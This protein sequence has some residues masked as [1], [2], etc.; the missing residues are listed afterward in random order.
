[1]SNPK[2]LK[3]VSPS[4]HLTNLQSP[5]RRFPGCFHTAGFP[6]TVYSYDIMSADTSECVEKSVRNR[7]VK[8]CECTGWVLTYKG[9]SFYDMPSGNVKK[10]MTSL[11]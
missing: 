8:V 5:N 4:Q 11:F 2:H 6:H 3:S 1:M 9:Q 10:C 7:F